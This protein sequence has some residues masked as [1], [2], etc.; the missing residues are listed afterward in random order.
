MATNTSS[1]LRTIFSQEPDKPKAS[2][3][4]IKLNYVVF[5]K[6]LHD[7][8]IGAIGIMGGVF[9]KLFSEG[10]LHLQQVGKI[11]SRFIHSHCIAMDAGGTC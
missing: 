2:F 7:G 8:M 5:L 4:L 11:V 3:Y 1:G 6:F 9:T 10:E